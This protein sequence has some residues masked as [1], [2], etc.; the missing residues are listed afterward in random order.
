MGLT[1]HAQDNVV[2]GDIDSVEITRSSSGVD[3]VDIKW[4]GL[5][6][7]EGDELYHVVWSNISGAM[8]VALPPNVRVFAHGPPAADLDAVVELTGDISKWTGL[9]TS[10]DEYNQIAML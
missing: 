9:V 10:E 5:Q 7:S 8:R 1:R 6:Q 4:S 2:R 3:E